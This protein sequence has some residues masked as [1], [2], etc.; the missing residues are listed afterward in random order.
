[1]HLI[2]KMNQS[3]EPKSVQNLQLNSIYHV[4]ISLTHTHTHSY[5]PQT[6][7]HTHAYLIIL[8]THTHIHTHDHSNKITCNLTHIHMDTFTHMYTLTHVHSHT[9]VHSHC[10]FPHTPLLKP[11][12]IHIIMEI[13]STHT[14]LQTHTYIHTHTLKQGNTYIHIYVYTHAVCFPSHS[15]FI[16]LNN[17]LQGYHFGNTN[18]CYTKHFVVFTWFPRTTIFVVALFH[19]KMCIIIILILVY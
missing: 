17:D 13:Q 15:T 18:T 5:I 4:V 6:L 10:A 8:L 16:K 1:M 11:T 14:Y 19:Y 7:L 9:Y 3:S 12:H 2:Y